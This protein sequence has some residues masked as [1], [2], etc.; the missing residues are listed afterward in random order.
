MR[1]S[2]TKFQND[3]SD[4]SLSNFSFAI[5]ICQRPDGSIGM[6]AIFLPPSV[7]A[8]HAIIRGGTDQLRET[9]VG[10]PDKIVYLTITI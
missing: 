9:D 3:C 4:L 8:S 5:L 1:E 7:A 6:E 2:A 10:P